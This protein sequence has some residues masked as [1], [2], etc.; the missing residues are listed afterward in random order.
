MEFFFKPVVASIRARKLL[1]RI[2]RVVVVSRSVL[3]FWNRRPS[4]FP[5]PHLPSLRYVQLQDQHVQYPQASLPSVALRGG[6]EKTKGIA[7]QIHFSISDIINRKNEQMRM[8]S[9]IGKIHIFFF[10]FF[11]FL[12]TRNLVLGR[13]LAC[14]V[15]LRAL[16]FYLLPF[17]FSFSRRMVGVVSHHSNQL[18]QKS[19]LRRQGNHRRGRKSSISKLVTRIGRAR[20]H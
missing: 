15:L 10:F 4:P 20:C 2:F 14:W 6:K 5:S 12:S 17:L 3:V 11:F 16:S 18:I 8:T 7:W 1:R 13:P 9:T 19:H